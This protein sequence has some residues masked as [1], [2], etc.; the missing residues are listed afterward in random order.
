M[1]RGFIWFQLER[2]W[3]RFSDWPIETTQG[4]Q[5]AFQQSVGTSPLR[6]Q[7]RFASLPAGTI[8]PIG[9]PHRFCRCQSAPGTVT[10]SSSSADTYVQRT[11]SPTSTA[12]G[13]ALVL[14]AQYRRYSAQPF[15]Q[16]RSVQTGRARTITYV[17]LN[18]LSGV[19]GVRPW[20]TPSK[21]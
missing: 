8:Q 18:I 1:L 20:S 12:G 13:S 5:A 9:G 21:P 4:Q 3:K 11:P 10:I 15:L 19:S 2:G 17:Q 16:F 6:L 14:Q 7:P